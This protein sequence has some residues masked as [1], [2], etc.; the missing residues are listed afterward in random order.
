MQL[1]INTFMEMEVFNILTRGQL[2]PEGYTR[3]P[4]VWA[5]A[6]THG[7]RKNVKQQAA[8]SRHI[9]GDT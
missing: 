3:I 2:P 9:T 4:I 8:G 1:E 7:R 6:N 5:F